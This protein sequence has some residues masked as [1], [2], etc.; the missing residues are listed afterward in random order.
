[1]GL[2]PEGPPQV[3]IDRVRQAGSR[4]FIGLL[5]VL[6]GSFIPYVGVVLELVGLVL[7]LLAFS[8]L[9]QE[10]REP[11]IFRY[12]LY[13]VIIGI[14]GTLIITFTVF[15]YLFYLATGLQAFHS[16]TPALTGTVIGAVV[17]AYVLAVVV[18]YLYKK[19]YAML[20]ER[21]ASLSQGAS[22]DFRSASKWYWIGS[23]LLIVVVGAVLLLIAIIRA[24]MG[25]H[26]LERASPPSQ[27]ATAA[28]A[29]F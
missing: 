16:G 7:L 20:A 8:A 19:V 17:A 1:M 10:L 15:A 4:G 18:G 6:I 24:M 12:T 28:A 29:T 11:K 5:L 26:D 23:L 22:D 27:P 25:F 13:A 21:V 14:A 9:S 3:N 2:A